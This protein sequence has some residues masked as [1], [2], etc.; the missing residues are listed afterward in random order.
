[1][2]LQPSHVHVHV[3]I[4]LQKV[5]NMVM[6]KGFKSQWNIQSSLH[7]HHIGLTKLCAPCIA[8]ANMGGKTPWFWPDFK[9]ASLYM[10]LLNCVC[11]LESSNHI[12]LPFLSFLS[13]KCSVYLFS[14]C[15]VSFK[16]IASVYYGIK[17]LCLVYS[18]IRSKSPDNEPTKTTHR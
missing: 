13:W 3:C 10:L 17:N 5:R 14:Y 4:H 1:M 6:P 2:V 15:S 7:L 9:N 12:G 11:R 18:W 16:I 8:E